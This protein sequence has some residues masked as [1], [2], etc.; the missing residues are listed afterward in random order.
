M[1]AICTEPYIRGG[2]MSFRNRLRIQPVNATV[3]LNRSA[4]V[5]KPSVFLGLSNG[6]DFPVPS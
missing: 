6:R 3:W 1:T 2:F 4:G 5:W